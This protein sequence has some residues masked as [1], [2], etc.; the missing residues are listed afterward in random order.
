[1]DCRFATSGVCEPAGP[2]RRR[3]IMI[4]HR[5]A[6][7][8]VACVL[9]LPGCQSLRE[10]AARRSVECSNLC[11]QAAAAHATGRNDEAR[12][13]LDRALQQHPEETEAR[14]RLAD[15]M[16]QLGRRDE[17]LEQF[18]R[19]ARESRSDVKLLSRYATALCET[20]QIQEADVWAQSAL[21]IDP[22]NAAAL[23]VRARCAAQRADYS[24]SL[25]A[26]HELLQ[27]APDHAEARLGMAQV[28]IARGQPELAAPVLRSLLQHPWASTNVQREAEWS[29]GRAYAATGR[30]E[31]AARLMEQS[32]A[33][34]TS[35]AD[36]WCQL[37]N[38]QARNGQLEASQSSVR[39]A[40][41]IDARHAGARQLAQEL[42]GGDP[43]AGVK[44]ARFQTASKP[45]E[46]TALHSTELESRE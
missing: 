8:C 29:L 21:T 32:V 31:E 42:A 1:M 41:E 27:I 46:R 25:A 23:L 44:P 39:H 17:A 33:Q 37:A 43:A 6:A 35:T 19:L 26:Y 28:Q 34:R 9:F 40:L 22:V 45:A 24:A 15:T 12:H 3:A 13:L 10:R 4:C 38:V 30:W 14:I 36:D 5:L 18:S 2:R 16:W 7:C 20:G 11:T